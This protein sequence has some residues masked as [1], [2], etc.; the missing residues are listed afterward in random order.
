MDHY[1]ARTTLRIILHA[2]PSPAYTHAPLQLEGR[3]D[4]GRH[5]RFFH[6]SRQTQHPRRYHSPPLLLLPCLVHHPFLAVAASHLFSG[7]PGGGMGGGA[8]RWVKI[9]ALLSLV[10]LALRA[11]SLLGHVVAPPP[12]S[13]RPS[14]ATRSARVVI[15]GKTSGGAAL[16][17]ARLRGGGGVGGFGDDKRM[18]PS[19][20][21]PLHNLR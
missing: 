14:A 13:A 20:S 9:L 2:T 3:D 15:S 11:G 16:A 1:A 4:A 8:V 21:N 12:T 18:A 7:Q 19:G 6:P 5:L 10:P 17:A